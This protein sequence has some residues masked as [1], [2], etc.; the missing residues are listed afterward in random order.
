MLKK[1]YLGLYTINY[2]LKLHSK[3]HFRLRVREK[4]FNLFGELFHSK[5][6]IAGTPLYKVG[7]ILV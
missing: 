3:R 1:V 6:R 5:K 7:K 4:V 2:H